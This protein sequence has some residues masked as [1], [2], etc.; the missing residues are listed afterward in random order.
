MTLAGNGQH[1]NGSGMPELEGRTGQV[2]RRVSVYNWSQE[3]VAKEFGIT[4]ARVS[5]IV[6]KVREQLKPYVMEEL[7]QNSMEFLADVHSRALQLA[8]LPGAPMTAGAQG[9][10][11]IDPETG[12]MVRDYSLRLKALATAM[13]VDREIRKMHGLNAPEKRAVTAEVRYEVVGVTDADLT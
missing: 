6:K 9:I 1:P 8:D 4:Q 13:D 3:R 7:V 12:Q 10:V 5:Q 11:V 2:W